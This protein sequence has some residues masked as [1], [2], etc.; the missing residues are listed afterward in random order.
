MEK[1]GFPEAVVRVILA[2]L[3]A[4]REL[5]RAGY[6]LAEKLV[7]ENRRMQAV[8]PSALKRM[9]HNQARILQTDT[10][11]AIETLPL[12]LRNKRDRQ[13]TLTLLRKGRKLANRPPNPQEQAVLDRIHKVL[14]T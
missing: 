4:D 12:L 7:R 8:P 3:L 2:I 5:P 1:G 6:R 11:Q 10:D 9:I 14:A 13:A